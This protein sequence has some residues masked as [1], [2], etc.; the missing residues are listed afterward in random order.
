MPSGSSQWMRL[1]LS[2]AGRFAS[3][4]AVSEAEAK[5][6][7]YSTAFG[8]VTAADAATSFA[9]HYDGY[10]GD[11]VTKMQFTD[12]VTYLPEDLLVKLDRMSMAHSIEGRCP[13]LDT[14]LVELGLSIPAPRNIGA[15]R[16]K[17]ILREAMG[18]DL[19]E[20]ILRRPKMGFS[21]PVAQWLRGELRESCVRKVMGAPLLDQGWFEPDAMASA[22]RIVHGRD[23]SARLCN[24]SARGMGSDTDHERGPA[25]SV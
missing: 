21:V 11:H 4:R 6:A 22:E 5:R 8:A 3:L 23:R 1:R 9:D 17:T 19:P 2:A 16:T 7:L 13:L 14:E 24:F 12:L 10:D 25:I 20:E 15:G 18:Q